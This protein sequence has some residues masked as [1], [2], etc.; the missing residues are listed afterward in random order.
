MLK[1]E[2]GMSLVIV[3]GAMLLSLM[4]IVLWVV[5]IQ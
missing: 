5:F 2:L 1:W 3:A 4:G